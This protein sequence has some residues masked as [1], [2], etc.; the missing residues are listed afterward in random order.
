MIYDT[1]RRAGYVDAAYGEDNIL[2]RW[3]NYARTGHSGNVA[4]RESEPAN[5][6]FSI[7]QRTSPDLEPSQVIALEAGWKE[8]LPA[9]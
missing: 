7:L 4:L 6:R 8:R 3:L 9:R 1:H 5:L 2:G